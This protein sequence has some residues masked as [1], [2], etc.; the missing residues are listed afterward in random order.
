MPF[1]VFQDEILAARLLIGNDIFRMTCSFFYSPGR[2]IKSKIPEAISP[3]AVPLSAGPL[4]SKEFTVPEISIFFFPP[5]LPFSNGTGIAGE[6]IDGTR[7][8]RISIG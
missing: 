7:S 1:T 5:L 6:S 3:P 8:L 4:F 2:D